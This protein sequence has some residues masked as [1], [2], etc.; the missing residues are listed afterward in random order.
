VL[1]ERQDTVVAREHLLALADDAGTAGEPTF[2][3]GL[4]HA[5]QEA[6]QVELA[7]RA[8]ETLDMLKSGTRIAGV[9]VRL[10]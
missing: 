8:W 5:R 9:A 6:L 3:Y 7:Y 1:G 2:T 10:K 4:L